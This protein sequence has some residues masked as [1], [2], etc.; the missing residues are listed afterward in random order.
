[1]Q[2]R[3]YYIHRASDA[4][5]LPS[6][7]TPNAGSHLLKIEPAW[8][9]GRVVLV[10]DAAHGMPPF[11]AEGTNQ[12]FEDA[13]AVATLVARL[14]E[15]NNLDDTKAVAEAFEKYER[16]RRPLI[17]HIQQATLGRLIYRPEKEW[18]EYNQ[19]VHGR[20]FNQVME[21]LI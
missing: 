2:Q 15:E 10:G 20:N 11:M 12:G 6:T 9:A 7:A 5:Q 13:A 1:M 4:I 3:P 16:L 17:V 14:A 19:R 21:A 18:Q 8:S